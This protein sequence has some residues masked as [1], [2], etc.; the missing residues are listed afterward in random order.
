M[1]ILIAPD[2][3][4]GS[5]TAHE[6]CEIT[7]GA[8]LEADPALD[9]E[10]VPLAD[11]GEGTA[12]VLTYNTQGR[13]VEVIVKDP[14]WRNIQATYGISDDGSTAFIEMAKASGLQLLRPHE[15]NPMT[16]TTFGT[17]QLIAHALD[18]GVAQVVLGIGGSATNDAG[19]GMAQALGFQFNDADG[20]M[21]DGQGGNLSSIHEI[22]SKQKHPSL[23]QASFFV[24]CDVN[25]PLHGPRG[26]AHVF[27][28]QKGATDEMISKLDEGLRHFETIARKF[29]DRPVNFPGAGAAGGLG[30]G[31]KL[32]LNATFESGIDYMVEFLGLQQKIRHAD[33]VITGEGKIDEQTLSGKVV[34]GITSLAKK[35]SK[36]TLLVCGICELS[37][38][39]LNKLGSNQLISLSDRETPPL[40]AIAK[41][42]EMLHAKVKK[43]YFDSIK[44]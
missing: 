12:D 17:G 1:K 20:K 27:A 21:L 15:R 33:L 23:S 30:A 6:V 34:K 10:V 16:T 22:L 35:N 39:Q 42:K 37:D 24:L 26:A 2:K 19:I 11:G 36:Q 43:W 25:N 4:K 3:F 38:S 7:S 41:A 32:F 18:Q 13:F 28:K 9:I 44:S 5:L 14:L 31:A 29:S 40:Q 8:L